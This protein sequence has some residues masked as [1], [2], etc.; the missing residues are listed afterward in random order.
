MASTMNSKFN[1]MSLKFPQKKYYI[2]VLNTQVQTVQIIHNV[3]SFNLQL[4]PL[5]VALL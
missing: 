5:N 2:A 4:W 3:I 1:T